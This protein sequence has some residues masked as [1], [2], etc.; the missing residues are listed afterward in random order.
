MS[1]EPRGRQSDLAVMDANEYKQKRRLERILDTRDEVQERIDQATERYYE[2]VI[3]DDARNIAILNAVQGFIREI[4]SLLKDHRAEQREA[5][6][7]ATESD[8]ESPAVAEALEGAAK[9]YRCP[10]WHG[11]G[12][13]PLGVIQTEK[14]SNVV[15]LGLRDI[16]EASEIYRE[17]WE[18]EVD[19]RHGPNQTQVEEH[20]YTVP[21]KISIRAFLLALTFLSDEKGM[22]IQVE[23][24]ENK[25]PSWGFE[26]VE[27]DDDE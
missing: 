4:H 9:E 11:N 27:R 5:L 26:E 16:H 10:Y 2:G 19:S 1:S 12:G 25:I 14:G 24:L 17:Q 18:E 20:V 22:D 6:R 8:E 13:D 23:E 15:F 7:K 3:T 21:R